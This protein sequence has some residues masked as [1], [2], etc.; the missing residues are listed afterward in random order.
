MQSH[1]LLLKPQNSS[2]LSQSI[3]VLH[4]LKFLDLNIKH[5]ML[6]FKPQGQSFHSYSLKVLIQVASWHYLNLKSYTSNCLHNPTL[7]SSS[8]QS[9]L[10]TGSS[11]K[12]LSLRFLC[13]SSK[14]LVLKHFQSIMSSTQSV[15]KPDL[16]LAQTIFQ[17]LNSPS[18]T[19]NWFCCT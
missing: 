1:V 8:F 17:H 2:Y 5:L 9:F 6:L 12:S 15:T 4:H 10:I 18:H 7:S 14:T 3:F 16:C 19:V 11:L 13:M